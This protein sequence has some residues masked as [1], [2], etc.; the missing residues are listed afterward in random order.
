YSSSRFFFSGLA[1]LTRGKYR[2]AFFLTAVLRFTPLLMAE[3]MSP[4]SL[5]DSGGSTSSMARRFWQYWAAAFQ[6][7]WLGST[8][9][10]RGGRTR[11][12]KMSASSRAKMPALEASAPGG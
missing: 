5:A 6:V 7:A 2:A 10:V 1:I 12:L 9:A 3:M 8:V 4:G 11:R